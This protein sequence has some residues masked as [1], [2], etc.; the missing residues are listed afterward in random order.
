VAFFDF[1]MTKRISQERLEHEKGAIRAALANDPARVRE[2]LAA[3]GFLALDDPS[4][5]SESISIPGDGSHRI[6]RPSATHVDRIS[7]TWIELHGVATVHP[8]VG[9]FVA[10][11]SPELPRRCLDWLLGRFKSST[12]L[13][14]SRS[15]TGVLARNCLGTDGAHILIAHDP[16]QWTRI[17]EAPSWIGP[18]AAT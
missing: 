16:D 12:R 13:A 5:T 11:G 1:A 4:I 3:L 8:G 17:R 18:A 14:G 7:V 2:E 9:D 15:N 10:T 6:G